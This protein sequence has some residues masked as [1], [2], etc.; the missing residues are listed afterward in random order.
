MIDFL[1]QKFV[2]NYEDTQSFTTRR[3]YGNLSSAVGLFINLF[4]FSTKLIIGLLTN[5]I[6][7]MA[8]AINNL[9]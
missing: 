9:S 7:I 2:K 3:S 8:D 6:A 1:I 4:L 5:S